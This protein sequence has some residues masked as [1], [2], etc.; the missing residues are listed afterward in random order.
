M[1][2]RDNLH[3][4]AA[5]RKPD[6]RIRHVREFDQNFRE[7]LRVTRL[8][9]VQMTGH[10]ANTPGGAVVVGDAVPA[11][12]QRRRIKEVRAEIAW[13]DHCD[14]DTKR[15]Q[16]AVQRFGQSFDRELGR[17]VDTK[18][19]R[20]TIT[21]DRRNIQNAARLLSPHLGQHGARDR[22]KPEDVC[23]IELLDLF[24]RRFFHGTEETEAGVIQKNVDAAELRNCCLDGFASLRLVSDVE[25]D[26][27]QPG[28]FA[29]SLGR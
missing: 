14:V 9:V 18:A 17:A 29:E 22:Q 13:L 28:M 2:G 5:E 4:V 20:S 12:R 19:R 11:D 7:L 27:E 6:R 1:L 21:A 8:P 23:A 24:R 3:G 15:R 25:R 26:G 16:F 10:F